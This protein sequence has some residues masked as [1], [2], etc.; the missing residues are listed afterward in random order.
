[1]TRDF[2]PF[3]EE[4]IEGTIQERFA[5]VVELC[6]DHPAITMG[7]RTLSYS[8][9]DKAS[10]QIAQAIVAELGV[11]PEP[12]PLLIEH[13]VDIIIALLGV[14][15]AGKFYVAFDLNASRSGM[16]ST[17]SDLQTRLI[18][19]DR[20]NYQLAQTL[21][22]PKNGVINI[23]EVKTF[24][25]RALTNVTC[26]PDTLATITY[27]SGTT[28]KPKGAER[29]HRQCIHTAKT[30]Y[31][32]YRL[33]LQDRIPFIFFFSSGV[34]INMLFGMLLGGATVYPY[35]IKK[36]GVIQFIQW[37]IQNKFTVLLSSASLFRQF[38]EHLEQLPDHASLSAVHLVIAATEQIYPQDI[39][40]FKEVFPE[41]CRL[42]HPYGLTETAGVTLLFI[43]RHTEIPLDIVPVGYPV[44]DQEVFILDEAGQDAGIDCIGEVAVRSRYLSPGYWRRP[45]LNRQKF[46][47]D[48][49]DSDK[50]I[51]HTGDLGRLRQ[52]GCLELQGRKDHEINM[53]GY[54]M[55]P[56]AI[57]TA[58]TQLDNVRD[59]II[60]TRKR[61]D[62]DV[63][64][65]AYVVPSSGSDLTVSS[66][67]REL[68]KTIP[69]WMIPSVFV[70]LER[71]PLNTAGK[72]DRQA[73]PEPDNT[74]PP[75]DTPFVPPTTAE[76]ILLAQIWTKTL[77]VKPVGIHDN[78]F[79]LGG[80]SLSMT[81]VV[82][83]IKQARQVE[84][85]LEELFTR[86][87][88]SELAEW[89][90]TH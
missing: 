22:V 88:I 51:Y 86:P 24:D 48:P 62:K 90:T 18:L 7:K 16:N 39:V 20:K 33:T 8:E 29:T 43:D 68:A 5:R 31:T 58:I 59:A 28:G 54:R 17:L 55:Y 75:L 44:K 25:T 69:M 23:D 49:E 66:I 50:R 84:L 78:F 71:L 83:Q 1:M 38:L 15:K 19:T 34:S 4:E 26:T 30:N 14:I 80:H 6:P 13:G 77:E 61:Q 42:A 40:R 37:F 3:D 57:A 53:R 87:T 12:I 67:R 81:E 74:R 56:P 60:I 65:I 79:E 73:L 46:F 70:L 35:D 52:D 10:N 64:L 85:P 21:T 2:L 11:E 47:S 76:E 27:T 36:N 41:T 72:V 32:D 9:L 82:A 63:F 89:L 45:E